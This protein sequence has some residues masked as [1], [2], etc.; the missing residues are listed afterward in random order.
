MSDVRVEGSKEEGVERGRLW[1][2]LDIREES[3]GSGTEAIPNR[4]RGGG[5]ARRSRG[6]VS[7]VEAFSKCGTPPLIIPCDTW[8]TDRST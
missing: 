8:N 7:T 6:E 1:S 3:T 4:V 5:G 2:S